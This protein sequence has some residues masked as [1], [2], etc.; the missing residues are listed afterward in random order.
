MAG[1]IRFGSNL[2]TDKKLRMRDRDHI[3]EV[4]ERDISV[5]P[6]LTDKLGFMDFTENE[7]TEQTAVYCLSGCDARLFRFTVL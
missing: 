3:R 7:C 6:A 2:T 5:G 4:K 1:C